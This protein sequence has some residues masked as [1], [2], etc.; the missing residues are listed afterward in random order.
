MNYITIDG[1]AVIASSISKD[2][3]SLIVR[4]VKSTATKENNQW[5]DK[6]NYF[7]IILKGDLRARFEKMGAKAGSSIWVVGP[8]NVTATKSPNQQGVETVYLNMTVFPWDLGYSTGSI[9]STGLFEATH[10]NVG[11]CNE[12]VVS[13]SGAVTYIDGLY[14]IGFGE[15]KKTEKLRLCFSGSEL[16]AF[17]ANHKRI[18]VIGRL[19][20]A[21]NEGKDGKVYANRTLFVKEAVK[22]PFRPKDK[23][24]TGEAPQNVAPAPAAAPVGQPAPQYEA[25]APQPAV[26]VGPMDFADFEEIGGDTGVFF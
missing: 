19:D 3:Q 18:D 24:E 14:D 15:N 9:G 4:C 5:V 10:T 13:R 23:N 26:S 22:A 11:L 17:V 25:P 2:G 12:P 1:A 20:V 16:P 7:S 6:P 21:A 8:Y